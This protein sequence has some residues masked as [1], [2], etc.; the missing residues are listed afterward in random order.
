[1]NRTSRSL[2]LAILAAAIG[3]LSIASDL[4]GVIG[5]AGITKESLANFLREKWP[6]VLIGALSIS[7]LTAI[8][9][10][11]ITR[12]TASNEA[13]SLRMQVHAASVQLEA[14]E[15][16]LRHISDEA[17]MLKTELDDHTVQLRETFT[18]YQDLTERCDAIVIQFSAVVEEFVGSGF[19]IKYTSVSDT[20]EARAILNAL[21]NPIRAKLVNFQELAKRA[22]AETKVAFQESERTSISLGE[23]KKQLSTALA[24][25]HVAVGELL[26]KRAVVDAELHEAKSTIES[27]RADLHGFRERQERLKSTLKLQEE[28]LRALEAAKTETELAAHFSVRVEQ[29]EAEVRTLSDQLKEAQ[30]ENQL[31]AKENA[32]LERLKLTRRR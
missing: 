24:D 9:F 4:F 6:F 19:F 17:A 21:T 16:S 22:L 13:E 25:R 28:Q 31:L 23:L 1:M 29:L 10:F 2:I 11:L 27:L 18:K 26:A 8:S 20:T 14:S 5:F 3:L 32:S 7:L 12:R 15:N 30:Q